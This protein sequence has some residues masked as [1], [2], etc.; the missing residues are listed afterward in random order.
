MKEEIQIT[1]IG[2]IILI[3]ALFAVYITLID[4]EIYQA[5][6]YTVIVGICFYFIGKYILE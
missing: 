6:L 1:L 2:V 5:I 4:I 3:Y